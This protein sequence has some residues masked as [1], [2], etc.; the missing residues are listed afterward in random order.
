MNKAP[1]NRISGSTRLDETQYTVRPKSSEELEVD[2][3]VI[4]E[5]D[6][7]GLETR[8]KDASGPCNITLDA[9]DIVQGVKTVA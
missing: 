6:A 9:E 3:F 2:D 4:A 8:S 7:E 5:V 1:E